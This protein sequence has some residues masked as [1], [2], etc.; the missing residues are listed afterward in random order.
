MQQSLDRLATDSAVVQRIAVGSVFHLL[1]QHDAYRTKAGTAAVQQ[2]LGHTSIVRCCDGAVLP[3]SLCHLE[4]T[5]K[6]IRLGRRTG[7]S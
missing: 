2:C 5:C 1:G 3:R 4:N 6:L 7:C